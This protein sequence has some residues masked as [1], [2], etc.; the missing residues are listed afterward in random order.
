MKMEKNIEVTVSVENMEEIIKIVEKAEKS[1]TEL[2]EAIRELEEK[3]I[4][5]LLES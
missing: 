5:I 1:I 3:K 4:N 2:K